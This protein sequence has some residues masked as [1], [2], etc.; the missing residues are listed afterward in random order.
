MT[1]QWVIPGECLVSIKFGDHVSGDPFTHQVVASGVQ[2]ASATQVLDQWQ[3]AT[4]AVRESAWNSIFAPELYAVPPPT[5]DFNNTTTSTAALD[6]VIGLIY[7]EDTNLYRF[8]TQLGIPPTF[9][10]GVYSN[11]S[12]LGL[13]TSQIVVVPTNYHRDIV[14]DDF[15]DKLPAETLYMGSVSMV[16]MNLIHVDLDTFEMVQVESMAGGF[17]QGNAFPE[18]VIYPPVPTLSGFAGITGL[19]YPPLSGTAVGL[20]APNAFGGVVGSLPGQPLITS[21]GAMAAGTLAPVGTPMGGGVPVLY[22]GNHYV[23]LNISCPR[24]G[25]HYRFKAC[26]LHDS[27]QIPLG[28]EASIYSLTFRAIPYAP[29]VIPS[30]P[31]AGY[32]AG[33]TGSVETLEPVTGSGIKNTSGTVT[34]WPGNPYGVNSIYDHQLDV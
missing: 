32:V 3:L 14:P 15:G 5:P 9:Q 17:V 28:S 34:N 8:L 18:S 7:L 22:S 26:Y 30:Q 24:T 27:H 20:H 4:P 25:I 16:K 11:L 10:P 1:R 31:V 21:M 13:S 23:S 19:G 33:L 6:N 29:V 12:E 2:V